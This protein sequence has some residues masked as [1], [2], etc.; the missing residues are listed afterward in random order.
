MRR[1]TSSGSGVFSFMDLTKPTTALSGHPE[2]A[3]HVGIIIAEYAILEFQMYLLY[4]CL[5]PVRA[6]VSF[7]TFF[8]LRSINLRCEI[9][10]NACEPLPDDLHRVISRV[11]RRLK[12]AA[13]RRTEIAHC[14]YLARGD[15]ILRMRWKPTGVVYEPLDQKVFARTITQFRTLSEDIVV[16][17][18]HVSG[19][20]TQMQYIWQEIPFP[21]NQPVALAPGLAPDQG[22]QRSI[23]HILACKARLGLE[24]VTGRPWPKHFVDVPLDLNLRMAPPSEEAPR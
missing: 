12:G 1:N 9:I 2:I 18:S 4:A 11:L 17:L 24:G 7:D 8:R 19:G 5:V 6:G 21:P 15:G 20:P 10:E 22:G 23:D 14:M 3:Q 13:T 16:L